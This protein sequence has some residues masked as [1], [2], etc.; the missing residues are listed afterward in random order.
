MLWWVKMLA[1]HWQ[2]VLAHLHLGFCQF[3]GQFNPS[4][5]LFHLVHWLD[6]I[7]SWFLTEHCWMDWSKNLPTKLSNFEISQFYFNPFVSVHYPW[8][9]FPL[10]F[11]FSSQSSSQPPWSITLLYILEDVPFS[12]A[13]KVFLWPSHFHLIPNSNCQLFQFIY[14]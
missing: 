3:I 13:F 6:L 8:P 2:F 11:L 1:F 12:F 5:F 7:F 10:I 9:Y 4:S 14:A